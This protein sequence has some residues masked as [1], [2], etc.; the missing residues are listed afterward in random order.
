[1]LRQSGKT[2]IVSTKAKSPVTE[3]AVVIGLKPAKCVSQ[4]SKSSIVINGLP[5]SEVPPTL[6]GLRNL[7][8]YLSGKEDRCE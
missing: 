7:R 2:Y 8:R 4:N 1:M 3:Q 6:T 5:K